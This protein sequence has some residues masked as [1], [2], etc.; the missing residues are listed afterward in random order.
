MYIDIRFAFNIL[1]VVVYT[2]QLISSSNMVLPLKNKVYTVQLTS[3]SNVVLPLKNE[4]HMFLLHS[5]VIH[6]QYVVSH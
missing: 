1:L 3:S 5:I 2:I 4:V 6:S